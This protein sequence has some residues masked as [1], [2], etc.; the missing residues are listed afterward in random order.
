MA[1]IWSKTEPSRLSVVPIYDDLHNLCEVL[2]AAN[3]AANDVL[4]THDREQWK[5]LSPAEQRL[6]EMQFMF[7]IGIDQKILD[8]LQHN[9]TKEVKCKETIR[10]FALQAENEHVHVDSYDLQARSVLTEAKYQEVVN[11]NTLKIIDKMHK[12]VDKWYEGPLADLAPIGTR[13]AA[14]AA[15]EGVMFSVSFSIFQ[16]LREH[17]ILDGL[18]SSNA[19]IVRD[20]GIH[21]TFACILIKKYLLDRPNDETVHQIFNELVEI[22]DEFAEDAFSGEVKVFGLML[23]EMKQYIK[24][25]ADCILIEMG[26]KPI[27]QLENPFTFME[28]LCLNDVN[29]PQHFEKR[30]TEY[31]HHG[32]PEFY[33]EN[34]D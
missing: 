32:A 30:P 19:Y 22:L 13:L 21:T 27:W 11:C 26:Y 1:F 34:W 7:L 28:K 4:F 2:K 9:F 23:S 31:Q 6:L 12:W 25:Q 29:K 8:N 20:E 3:W 5:S 17:R 33:I 18:A 15:I 14:F 10:F 16:Q 24:F